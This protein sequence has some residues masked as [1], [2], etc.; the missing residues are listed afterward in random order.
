MIG[1]CKAGSSLPHARSGLFHNQNAC[2]SGLKWV[3]NIVRQNTNCAVGLQLSFG[4]CVLGGRALR[5]FNNKI[6][7]CHQLY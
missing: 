5:K 4:V 1:L 7:D 6:Q 3:V 2:E